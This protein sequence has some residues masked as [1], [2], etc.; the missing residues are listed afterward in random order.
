VE[1]R[2]YWR[3]LAR[4]RNVIR[5]TVLIVAV[6]GLL[7][8]VY[9]YAGA[10]YQGHAQLSVAVQPADRSRNQIYDVDAAA[11]ANTTTAVQEL[12]KYAATT[13]Y[14]RDVSAATGG[15]TND[16]KA[17]QQASKIYLLPTRTTSTSSMMG[18]T[19]TNLL[20]SSGRKRRC[21]W[22]TSGSSDGHLVSR[23][24]SLS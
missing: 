18:R 23:P 4:R 12:T 16:C 11:Q 15:N 1:L 19:R 24:S 10:L 17:I 2:Y 9:S 13:Q 21:W 14:F 6:L 3:V 20:E 7:T 22:R 5:N 8:V